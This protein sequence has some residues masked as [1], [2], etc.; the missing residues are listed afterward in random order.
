MN[1]YKTRF[2]LSGSIDLLPRMTRTEWGDQRPLSVDPLNI[3]P[4]IIQIL[5]PLKRELVWSRN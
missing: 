4:Q 3:M 1:K 2:Q 5:P